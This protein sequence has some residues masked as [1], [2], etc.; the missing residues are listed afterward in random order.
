MRFNIN[1]LFSI[2]REDEQKYVVLI[3]QAQEKS[4]E[5]LEELFHRYWPLIRR[6][7]QQYYVAG[8]ELADWEQE[9]KVIMAEILQRDDTQNPRMFSSFLKHCLQNKIRDIRRQSLAHKRIPATQL[10]S[11]DANCNDTIIDPLHGSPDDIVY[12]HQSIELLLKRCSKFEC[13]VLGY[14]HS[15]YTLAETAFYLGCSKRSVQ[16]AIHRCRN[17]LIKVLEE[18]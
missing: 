7:W 14:L 9:A 5:A 15:G 6:L 3:K 16:S 2:I 11:L 17:K 10:S 1:D 13:R 18:K 4:D 12:C 8:Y